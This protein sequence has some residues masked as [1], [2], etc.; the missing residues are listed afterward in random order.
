MC[1]KLKTVNLPP[2]YCIGEWSTVTKL[3]MGGGH[4]KHDCATCSLF[5]ECGPFEIVLDYSLGFHLLIGR[6]LSEPHSKFCCS[7]ALRY[8]A[9]TCPINP[10]SHWNLVIIVGACI[11]C[12]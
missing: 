2:K 8:T 9:Q 11:L 3:A 4:L 5:G 10:R 12:K 1:R 7:C 6:S